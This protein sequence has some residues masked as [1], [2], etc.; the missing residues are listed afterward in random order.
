M[1]GGEREREGGRMGWGEGS[2]KIYLR[3]LSS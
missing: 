2:N 3:L 1:G